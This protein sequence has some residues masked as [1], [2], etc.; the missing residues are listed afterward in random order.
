MNDVTRI[1][2]KITI[3]KIISNTIS[4]RKNEIL[5]FQDK[6]TV[7]A[8]TLVT[9]RKTSSGGK[10]RECVSVHPIGVYVKGKEICYERDKKIKYDRSH[11]IPNIYIDN[12]SADVLILWDQASNQN[13]IKK[14]IKKIED[15]VEK[16]VEYPFY[17]LTSIERQ[18]RNYAKWNINIIKDKKSVIEYSGGSRVPYVW[19]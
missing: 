2:Q 7:Q 9:G 5:V 4:F 1:T 11:L 3:D 16:E 17:W 14:S 6:D 19:D 13:T 8:V 12:S 18:D 10:R 15:R